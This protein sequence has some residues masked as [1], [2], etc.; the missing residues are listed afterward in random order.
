MHAALLKARIVDWRALIGATGRGWQLLLAYV[1][2]PLLIGY[3][4]ISRAFQGDGLLPIDTG[5]EPAE[6]FIQLPL[7]QAQLAAGDLPKINLF[8][9]F[10][11]PILGEPVVY[12][13]ALHAW[14][15]AVFRP[16]VAMLVNKFCLAVLS[17]VILTVFFSRYF[18]PLISSF[19]AFLT[20]SSPAFFYFFQNHPHQGVLFYYGLILVALR[21]FLDGPTA[22]RGFWLYATFLFFFLS[23]GINGALLGT[24]FVL[25]YA[26][27]VAGRRWKALGWALGLWGAAGVAVY[28]HFLE[29]FRLAA[30]SARK[31]LD[32]QSLTSVNRWELIKGLFFRG[33]QV[34]QSDVFYS[35]PVI[36][37]IAGGLGW[38]IFKLC[39]ASRRPPG[40]V[41]VPEGRFRELCRL[42]FILGLVPCLAVIVCRLRPDLPAAVPLLKAVNVPRVLWFSDAFLL[43]AAGLAANAVYQAARPYPVLW[44]VL[45]VIS[46]GARYSA[47]RAQAEFFCVTESYT[48]F[49]PAEFLQDMKPYM[50]LATLFDPF[51]L[52]Q[53]T[54]ANHKGILG[55][56]GRSI[57]LDKAFRDYLLKRKLIELGYHGMTYFFLPAPPEVLARFGIRYCLTSGREDQLAEWG[58]RPLVIMQDAGRPVF[59][60][61]GNPAEV[62]PLYIAG[63]QPEFLQRYRLAG[64]AI[65]AE[66]PPKTSAYEVVATFLARP[67]WKAF[68]NGQPLPIESSEEHFIRVRVAP[69][70]SW[71]KLLLKYEP[72]SN[73]WLLG[74]VVFSFAGA[75]LLCWLLGRASGQQLTSARR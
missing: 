12:P 13:F 71:Q 18:L 47:F 5:D 75:G 52:S 9:N 15:Y 51:P 16:V 73:A 48:L 19:C 46:L 6:T 25:T 31:D 22:A 57:I 4:V 41:A 30:A 70:Q 27:L 14:S 38:A 33:D 21:W 74:C 64:N 36:A 62:T 20:F 23:V 49:Q 43:L 59:A 55:S 44:V 35:A 56:A 60:L 50:R 32:Y 45:L 65:E 28:P 42:L 10:G 63:P 54:K 40:N 37:L 17:M 1:L 66:L 72:Y 26:L 2:I 29:F 53:D 8:N 39:S 58:W 34:P 24:G 3:C 11:T 68:I 69:S 61:Y 67:G 7:A